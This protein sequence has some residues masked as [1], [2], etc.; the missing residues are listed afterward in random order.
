[1]AHH[2]RLA[3]YSFGL[4][5]REGVDGL[6]DEGGVVGQRSLPEGGDDLVVD[7]ADPDGRVGQVDDASPRATGRRSRGSPRR[8]PSRSRPEQAVDQGVP[9]GSNDENC[10]TGLPASAA[11]ITRCQ[12]WPGRR[13]PLT[14]GTCRRHDRLVVV[15]TDPNG[16]GDARGIADVPAVG[17]FPVNLRGA[18]LRRRRPTASQ[19]QVV[20]GRD[21]DHRLRDVAG[22]LPSEHSCWPTGSRLDGRA[23]RRAHRRQ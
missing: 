1:M 21:V 13:R 9:I 3:D 8:S 16:R 6:R 7:P 15:G 10:C 5:D 17:V 14:G 12:I 20:G 18:R 22:Q 23:A 19:G 2:D 4:F 11:F